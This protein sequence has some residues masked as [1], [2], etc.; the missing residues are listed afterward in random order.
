M[1]DMMLH[2][3][4]QA[5]QHQ[6]ELKKKDDELALLRTKDNEIAKLKAEMEKMKAQHQIELQK[7]GQN[8]TEERE[9]LTLQISKDQ[10]LLKES[11]I[12]LGSANAEL[13]QLRKRRDDCIKELTRIL[14]HISR[15]FLPTYFSGL[16][17]MS[18]LYL[19][20]LSCFQANFLRASLLQAQQLQIFTERGVLL[21][22]L[23]VRRFLTT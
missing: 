6:A 15:K 14:S 4:E 7:V 2:F 12:Q 23:L 22:L 1:P 13:E 18:F 21:S 9:R 8:F 3:L 19:L 11:D 16:L 20:P 10:D 5:G 17:H